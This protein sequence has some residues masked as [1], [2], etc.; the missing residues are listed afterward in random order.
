MKQFLYSILIAFFTL[1]L[2]AEI[3]GPR[4][5]E[6]IN[7]DHN[8]E[9]LEGV[10]VV[11]NFGAHLNLDLIV[12]NEEGEKVPLKTYFKKGRPVVINMV[13]YSCGGT[14]NALLTGSFMVL[15]ELQWKPG[16]QFE[17]LNISFEPK[18]NHILAEAKKA[19][20]LELYNLDSKGIHFLTTTQEVATE[21]C[22]TLGFKYKWVPSKENP[23]QGDYSHPSVTHILT[24][25]GKISRYLYGISF[26][27]RDYKFAITEAGEGK[28]GSFAER[29]L[30]F[31]FQYDKERGKYVR[32]AMRVMSLGGALTLLILGTFL[33][34]LW[35]SELFKKNTQTEKL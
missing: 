24:E 10:T 25:D 6:S 1:S 26:P 27:A 16:E 7:V 35:K 30:V 2:S 12:S 15:N 34:I 4:V 20:Y 18:E 33:G 3:N 9:E 5:G 8:P 28:I 11:E 32:N 19:N 13:Y 22:E 29:I 21:I 23:E 31:C 17:M 14:C